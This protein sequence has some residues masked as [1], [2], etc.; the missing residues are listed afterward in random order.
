MDEPD[1]FLINFANEKSHVLNSSVSISP[2]KNQ[3]HRRAWKVSLDG[4]SPS[5]RVDFGEEMVSIRVHIMSRA[6][7]FFD[8]FF[9]VG[10]IEFWG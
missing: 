6:K 5:P 3:V 4:G 9:G 1:K 2:V 10:E 7:I 8:F